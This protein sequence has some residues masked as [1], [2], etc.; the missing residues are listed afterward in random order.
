M[1]NLD[2]VQRHRERGRD[3]IRP[4]ARS[5]DYSCSQSRGER[6]RLPSRPFIED[7][8]AGLKALVVSE[9]CSSPITIVLMEAQLDV[10]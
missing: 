9:N 8:C 7:L 4:A 2:C 10:V 6:R 3:R 1:S 5:A